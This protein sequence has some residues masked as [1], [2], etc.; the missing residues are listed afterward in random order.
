MQQRPQTSAPSHVAAAVQLLDDESSAVA[1]ACRN[2]LL[3]WGELARPALE[4]VAWSAAERPLLRRAARGVL[5]SIDLLVFSRAA[6]ESPR[7]RGRLLED[8]IAVLLSLGGSM[9]ASARLDGQLT[10]SLIHISEPTRPY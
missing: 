3:D 7:A 8:G 2:Q 1:A 6:G 4:A 5:R 10:L 9:G